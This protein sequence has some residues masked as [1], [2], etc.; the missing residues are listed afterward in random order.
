MCHT[1]EKRP[2]TV[3]IMAGI[4]WAQ[5]KQ[6]VQE[7]SSDTEVEDVGGWGMGAQ[8]PPAQVSEAGFLKS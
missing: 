5:Q 7:V 2:L 4:L 6:E 8:M 3:V 1:L